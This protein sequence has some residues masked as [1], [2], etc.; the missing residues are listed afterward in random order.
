MEFE[1]S[2]ELGWEMVPPQYPSTMFETLSKSHEWT[3]ERAQSQMFPQ[4]TTATDPPMTT[5][6]LREYID[7]IPELSLAATDGDPISLPDCLWMDGRPPLKVRHW[8]L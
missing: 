6:P 7:R 3:A 5:I 4:G 8:V 2:E 1:L